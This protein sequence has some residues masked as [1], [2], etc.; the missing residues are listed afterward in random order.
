MLNKY[1][2]DLPTSVSSVDKESSL[3][4]WE[5]VFLAICINRP[6]DMFFP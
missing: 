1:M 5:A 4:W 3:W 2:L 6:S